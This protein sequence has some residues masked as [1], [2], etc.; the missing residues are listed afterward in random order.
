MVTLYYIGLS[1]PG[2]SVKFGELGQFN[3]PGLPLSIPKNEFFKKMTLP[4]TKLLDSRVVVL[5]EGL[6][7]EERRRY[8]LLYKDGEVLTQDEFFNIVTYDEDK[9]VE[10]YKKLCLEHKD[11]VLKL[12]AADLFENGGS[13]TTI[14][15]VKVMKKICTTEAPHLLSLAETILERLGENA[16]KD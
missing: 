13:N 7:E 16:V 9:L 8:G 10:R 12:F 4:V 2:T 15:K 11:V 3:R 14:S 6:T 5:D 1:A